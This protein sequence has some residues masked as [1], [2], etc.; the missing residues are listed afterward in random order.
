MKVIDFIE[1][2]TGTI[3]V[4]DNYTEELGVA[5]CGEKLTE[6]GKKRFAEALQLPIDHF[7]ADI[8]VIE[9]DSKGLTSN[10][11]EHRLEIAKELF[12]SIAGMCSAAEWDKWFTE[13]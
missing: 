13:E 1:K 10:Q 7:D 4:T 12:E 5:Y 11:S 6:A 9:V 3:D 8:L 2:F